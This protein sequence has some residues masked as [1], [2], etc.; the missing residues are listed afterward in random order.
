MS[1]TRLLILHPDATER[2]M[3]ITMLR[4]LGHRIEEAPSDRAAIQVLD[5]EPADLVLA[6]TDPSDP[7]RMEFLDYLRRNHPQS[8]SILL[9]TRPSFECA[10][11]ATRRGAASVLS[12]PVAGY[13]LRAA[14]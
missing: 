9:L 5:R 10:R 1:N 2:A 13:P 4:G 12:L 7:D 11:D 6:C 14:V 8:R 3:L